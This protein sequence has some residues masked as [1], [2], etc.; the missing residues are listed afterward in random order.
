MF[1]SWVKASQFCASPGAI[2]ANTE[3]Q[4]LSDG[5]LKLQDDQTITCR[6]L[7]PN[8]WSMITTSTTDRI[9]RELSCPA[10]RQAQL[11]K[12]YLGHA[13]GISTSVRLF[14]GKPDSQG[15]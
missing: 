10:H 2:C 3:W 12:I 11:V 7:K 6:I 9:A 1:L 5:T 14:L 15:N 8:G 13:F 4:L